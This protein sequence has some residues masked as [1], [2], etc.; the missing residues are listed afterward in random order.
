MNGG[1]RMHNDGRQQW[2]L[3][4]GK[5]ESQINKMIEKLT[6]VN[7][8]TNENEMEVRG[9]NICIYSSTIGGNLHFI[10]P[11]PASRMSLPF[12]VPIL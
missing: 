10:V 6:C 3:T 1:K 7:K 8:H 11:Y 9:T 4:D 5:P 12:E 2:N